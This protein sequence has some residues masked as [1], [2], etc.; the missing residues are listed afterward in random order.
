[1]E[2]VFLMSYRK[3]VKCSVCGKSARNKKRDRVRRFVVRTSFSV[4]THYFCEQ[5]CQDVKRCELVFDDYE[6]VRENTTRV[7]WFRSEFNESAVRS[8]RIRGSHADIVIFDDL[9]G[10]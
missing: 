3:H 7:W 8:G 2:E 10:S 1:M 9:G 5:S 4:R 6:P